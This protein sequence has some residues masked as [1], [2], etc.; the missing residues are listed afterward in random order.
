M[1]LAAQVAVS[2]NV[3]LEGADSAVGDA[4]R[5][6][7]AERGERG[8]ERGEG[9]RRE[10]GGRRNERRPIDE[11]PAGDPAAL[12]S[13]APGADQPNVEASPDGQDTARSGGQRRGRDR[14]GRERRGRGDSADVQPA[15]GQ[16]SPVQETTAEAPAI[17]QAS[18]GD[19]T[20]ARS[21][22]TRSTTAAAPAPAP[23][24][25]EATP[26]V[27]VPAPQAAAPAVPAAE[28]VAAPAPRARP[29]PVEQA[30]PAVASAAATGLPKVQPFT[31]EVDTLA[32]IAQA[33]GLVWVH[34]DSDK[35]Q[36]A[37]AAIAAEPKPIHVPREPKPV[38]ALDE[39]PLVL[40]ETRRDLRNMVLPFEQNT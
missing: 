38:V 9:A 33:S 17:E 30:V 29:A 26:E 22:F 15:E 21:Y 31:L 28:P 7:R 6:D 12:N 10:R 25:A 19:D 8:G 5:R 36:Q 32:N 11:T 18:H 20:P 4:P 14:Y 3:A 34:S 24:P 35:V 37:Q 13:D 27:D 2:D 16:E 40:V 23:A 39:G 1:G